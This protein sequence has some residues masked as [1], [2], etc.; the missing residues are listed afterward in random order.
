MKE[1]Q[2]MFYNRFVNETQLF[3]VQA[4]S[5][6][7]AVRLFYLRHNRKAYHPC[8][9]Y[10]REYRKPHFWSEEEIKNKIKV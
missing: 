8:I 7:K 5:E 10:I 4:E 3:F 6:L 1:Y 9:E 2:I